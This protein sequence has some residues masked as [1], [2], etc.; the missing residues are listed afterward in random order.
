MVLMRHGENKTNELKVSTIGML[1]LLL[2]NDD[3]IATNGI[4]LESIMGKLGLDE[5]TAVKNL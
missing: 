3:D 4:T 5:D 2:F 1:I